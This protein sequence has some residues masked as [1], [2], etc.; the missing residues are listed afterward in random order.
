MSSIQVLPVLGFSPSIGMALFLALGAA[1]VSAQV[2]ATVHPAYTISNLRPTG[3]EPQVS[4]LDFLPD[5]RLAVLTMSN[6]GAEIGKLHILSGVEKGQASQV[7]STLFAEGLNEPL[8]LKVVDGQIYV[9]EKHQLTRLSDTNNDGKAD[10]ETKIGPAWKYRPN[11]VGGEGR[12]LEFAM[13]LAYKAETFYVG[14]ATFWPL[15]RAQDRERGCVIG[16]KATATSIDTLACGLRTPNGG[17]LGPEDEVFFTEN[18]GNWVPSSKLVHIKRGRFFGVHKPTSA[19]LGPFDAS[20]ETPPVA[21]LQH[22]DVSVSPT[23]PVL[24]KTGPFA[25]HMIAGD[26]GNGTLQRFFIEK[27]K[28]EFQAA[29]FRFSGGLDAGVNR[30]VVGPDSALYLG[31]MGFPGNLWG[32]WA[33]NSKLFGLQRMAL[34]GTTPFDWLAVRSTGTDKFELEFTQPV[35]TSADALSAYTVRQWGYIPEAAYGQRRG[36]IENLT[37]K[38]VS[39][40]ADRKKVTLS[41]DGLKARN[42]VHIRLNNVVAQT[43]GTV[44]WSR[45]AWYTLNQFG[46]ADVPVALH[47]SQARDASVRTIRQGARVDTRGRLQVETRSGIPVGLRGVSSSSEALPKILPNG[48]LSN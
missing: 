35:S 12:N 21:W 6:F 41:I 48:R 39:V 38:A 22:T 33:W 36:A 28:G 9:V 3:F 7:T 2:H 30:I 5:G 47:Q 43:G 23:Q 29:V 34:N 42:V 25:G 46:P 4:G 19:G 10:Q 27:V 1:E 16:I 45:E 17:N 11:Q 8:G 13:G 14:L 26:N 15:D 40:S 24:L 37:P 18:Q 31:G 44:S 20:P 32:G